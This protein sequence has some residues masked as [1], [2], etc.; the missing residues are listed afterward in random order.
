M[1][2]NSTKMAGV[3]ALATALTLGT[4]HADVGQVY[5]KEAVEA[6]PLSDRL[7]IRSDGERYVGAADGLGRIDTLVRLNLHV[8]VLGRIRNWKVWLK[9]AADVSA[10]D[11]VPTALPERI[12]E[13]YPFGARPRG[14]RR[15]LQFPVDFSVPGTRYCNVLAHGLRAQGLSDAEIFAVDR[16]A[17]VN[18]SPALSFDMSG[19]SNI[20]PVADG[21]GSGSRGRFELVCLAHEQSPPPPPPMEDDGPQRTPLASVS[22]VN[23]GL[24]FDDQPTECPTT[25]TAHALITASTPGRFTA[26]LRDAFGHTSQTRE[27]EMTAAN[28]QGDQYVKTFQEAFEVGGS[29][30]DEDGSGSAGGG[31]EWVPSGLGYSSE[32]REEEGVAVAQGLSEP[33]DKVEPNHDPDEHVNAIRVE[34]VSAGLGSVRESGPED[35]HITCETPTTPVVPGAGAGGRVIEERA[36]L[37]GGAV[38]ART[39]RGG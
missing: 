19:P 11:A 27:F 24:V 20:I 18:L 23:L 26:R 6:V 10:F 31:L 35:Y 4:A 12:E 30:A 25:V 32:E 13:S 15:D 5:F 28:R 36:P 22:Y 33:G 2:R 39:S 17:Q 7:E 37:D 16:S 29:T 1:Y 3:G 9:S 38:T 14:V 8:G 34:I 21:V